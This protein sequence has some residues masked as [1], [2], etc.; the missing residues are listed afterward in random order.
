MEVLDS[1]ESDVFSTLIGIPFTRKRWH[2]RYGLRLMER[3]EVIASLFTF[4]KKVM[5][6]GL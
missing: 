4:L 1:N 3:I 2:T 5:D 6:L